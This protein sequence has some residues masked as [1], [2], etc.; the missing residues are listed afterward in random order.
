MLCNQTIPL[1]S[2]SAIHGANH[3][4]VG[5]GRLALGGLGETGFNDLRSHGP[6]LL[7]LSWA[8][9][10]TNAVAKTNGSR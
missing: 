8:R 6:H 4:N 5:Q 1:P 2:H 7:T 10:G 9:P 3:S